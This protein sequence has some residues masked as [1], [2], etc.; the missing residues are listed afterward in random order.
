MKNKSKTFLAIS[1]VILLTTFFH[2]IG[3]LK[4]LENLIRSFISPVS[5]VMYDLSL[6]IKGQNQNFSTVEELKNAYIISEEKLLEKE[7]FDSQIK[8]VSAENE[9]LRKE[10]NFLKKNSY[11]TLG[12]DVIGKNIDSLGNTIIINR[13]EDSNLKVGQSVVVSEGVLIGKIIKVEKSNSVIRLI[14]D[15]QS[16]IAATILNENKSIGLVEGG[17]GI[18]IYLNFVPQTEKIIIGDVVVT[19]G[20]ET[21]IP[22]GLLLG[23]V[24]AVE[25]EAYQPFQKAILTPFVDLEKIF[26]VSVILI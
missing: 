11:Q 22:K 20:L 16:K 10:L 24:E 8:L 18:S 5:K 6:E 14:N 3:L 17:Y 26:V 4:P 1:V 19:S 21:N 25:K 9:E 7:I 2:Y 12:A 13:G 23:K 15:N